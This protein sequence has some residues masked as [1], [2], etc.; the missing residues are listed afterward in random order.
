MSNAQT[1]ISCVVFTLLFAAAAPA[2]DD[3]LIADFEADT[4]GDWQATGDAFGAG[5]AGGTLANQRPVS[6]FRGKGLVNTYLNGDRTTG[7]LTSPAFAIQRDYLTFL[8]GGGQHDNT[9]LQ[10]L[11]DDKVVAAASG[12]NDEK[13]NLSMFDVGKHKGKQARLRIVD[14]NRGGW[15]HVNVDHIV[16]SDTK[17]EVPAFGAFSREFTINKKYLVIPIENGA[18]RTKLT[19]SVDGKEVRR[20]DT[21]LASSGDAADWY[22]FFT[23]DSYQGRPAT[24]SVSSAAEDGF[25]LIKQADTVPGSDTWYTEALRPQ[26]HFSQKVGWNNDPNG[27]CYY[28]GEWHLYFQHN[29]VG[30][31]WGNMTWGHAVSK[32]L[33]HWEQLPNVLFPGTMATGACFSG[34]GLVDHRNT[35][36]FKTGAEDVIVA[37]LTDTGAGEALAYSNDR[38]RTFTWYQGNPVVKHK[39]RDPKVIWYKYDKGD[40]PLNDAA[41]KL[42][43]HWVMAVYDEHPQHKRNIAF[44]TSTNLKEWTG[45]SHLPGYF[46][47]P[48]ILELPV[49]DDASKSRW[50]VFAADAQYTIGAFDGKTFTPEHEGKHRVHHGSYYA[51]QIFSNAPDGRMIQIGWAR[52]PFPGMPFNQTFTF[53]HEL[54][55]RTTGDGIRLFAEPVKQIEKLHG[56]RHTAE[57]KTLAEN[58][59]AAVNVS[60][61]LFDIRATFEIGSAAAVGLDIGGERITYDAKANKLLDADLKPV[62]GKVAIRVLVDRPMIEVI[63]TGGRVY[64]TRARGQKGEVSTISAF[65]AGGEAKLI[66]LEVHELNSIWGR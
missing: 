33:V 11:I 64:I 31:K 54:T 18:K 53:P 34:G 21:E 26:F 35:G 15:G 49:D 9:C 50:V 23:I 40:K 10:L 1:L 8:I 28:D 56:K 45:Q 7:T 62:D 30:W 6:G 32:D 47:C 66:Q 55:L 42:G 27:M 43:G 17:P 38:G 59:P 65:A 37:F 4:Y 39:G 60:G 41:A 29:P 3:I 5:P 24:V 22:A 46:E 36:G 12:Q 58:R 16:H 20:Y 2:A 19:L 61:E 25:A 63:G 51:S 14:E 52:F 57:N 48:E 44:Y 13:L